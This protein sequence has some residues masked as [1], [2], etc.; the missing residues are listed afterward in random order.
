MANL[1]LSN[2]SVN[3]VAHSHSYHD[4][5]GW[6]IQGNCVGATLPSDP[7]HT[8]GFLDVDAI[9]KGRRSDIGKWWVNQ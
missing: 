3:I 8:F 4:I 5:D 7:N 9:S 1:N 6:L 2:F